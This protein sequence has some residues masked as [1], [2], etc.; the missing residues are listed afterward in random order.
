MVG[1]EKLETPEEIEVD[2]GMLRLTHICRSVAIEPQSA[3]GAVTITETKGYITKA[4]GQFQGQGRPHVSYLDAKGLQAMLE[5]TTD[6]KRAGDFR[7][8]DI[9][10]FMK[11]REDERAEEKRK[12][13]EEKAV[14][15]AKLQALESEAP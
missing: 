2:S 12:K 1:I 10:I 6:G 15:R 3:S 8:S 5:D 7:L 13:D 11:K 4:N 9:P 14:A